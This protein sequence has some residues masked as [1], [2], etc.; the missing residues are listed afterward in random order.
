MVE[1]DGGRSIAVRISF[2]E[3][4]W[5]ALTAD[6]RG[7][8]RDMFGDPLIED[9]SLNERIELFLEVQIGGWPFPSEPSPWGGDLDDGVPF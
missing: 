5:E 2:S 7:Y 4:T 1:H 9:M 6:Y 3:E 8:Y